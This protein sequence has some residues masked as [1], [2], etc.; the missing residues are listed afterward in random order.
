[1]DGTTQ[2]TE[3]GR[4]P[5]TSTITFVEADQMRLTTGIGGTRLEGPMTDASGIRQPHL[6]VML[7]FGGLVR[8]DSQ[9]HPLAAY[10][11]ASLAR[12]NNDVT[13]FEQPQLSTIIR[14]CLYSGIRTM[15]NAGRTN[16][17]VPSPT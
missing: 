10:L 14:L 16:I 15:W 1:M 9:T 13:I 7:G 5:I 3:V 2:T 11:P 12:L 6:H 4:L 8:D 17:T